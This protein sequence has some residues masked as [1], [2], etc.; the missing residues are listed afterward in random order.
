M[1][2]NLLVR[3]NRGGCLLTLVKR[4]HKTNLKIFAAGVFLGMCDLLSP[5][6]EKELIA[7]K[8]FA[9]DKFIPRS[10]LRIWDI[11]CDLSCCIFSKFSGYCIFNP[12]IF[13]CFFR[14]KTCEVVKVEI[15]FYE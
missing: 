1:I 2:V 3:N 7:K 14:H 15:Y 12:W 11:L 13:L 5:D 6:I 9:Q 4:S 10:S 8:S